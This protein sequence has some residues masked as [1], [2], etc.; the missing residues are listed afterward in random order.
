MHHVILAADHV[1][2][3][4]TDTPFGCAVQVLPQSFSPDR[5]TITQLK[6]TRDA[7]AKAY[8]MAGVNAT[9]RHGRSSRLFHHCRV[10]ATEDLGL[11]PVVKGSLAER[12]GR[13]NGE[14]RRSTPVGPEIKG[15]LGATGTGQVVE[16]F[17]QLRGQV[18][19]NRQVEMQK[20]H[21]AQRG[22]S[23][24][25]CAVVFGRDRS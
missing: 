14:E 7:S 12:R 16:V 11:Q 4:L 23:G 2:K 18:P 15:P 8:A 17:K 9:N 13:L 10:L 25:T 21:D 1:A 3:Q 6:A 24:A 22:G 20:P 19:T 5:P